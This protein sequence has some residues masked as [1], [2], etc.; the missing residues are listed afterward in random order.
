[1][2][3]FVIFGIAGYVPAGGYHPDLGDLR[4]AGLSGNSGS[5]LVDATGMS[6]GRVGTGTH[7]VCP[8]VLLKTSLK[9]SLFC[10]VVRPGALAT[11]RIFRIAARVPKPVH[12]DFRPL[13]SPA[14]LLAM[15]HVVPA[16]L[17][18]IH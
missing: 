1:M 13:R 17:P 3:A 2:F 11:W 12:S 4:R 16:A 8:R 14:T 7:E 5:P 15:W 10:Q 18:S 9:E 6:P